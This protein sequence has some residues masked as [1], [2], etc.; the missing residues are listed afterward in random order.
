LEINAEVRIL[1]KPVN[2]KEQ[3]IEYYWF[4]RNLL[5][6]SQSNKYNC[7]GGVGW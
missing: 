5:I 2:P 7:L 1:G 3:T 4:K 6:T